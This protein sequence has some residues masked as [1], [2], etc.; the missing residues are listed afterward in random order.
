[1]IQADCN[2]FTFSLQ[3]SE[4]QKVLERNGNYYMGDMVSTFIPGMCYFLK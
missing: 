4:R 2:I 3:S 1:M